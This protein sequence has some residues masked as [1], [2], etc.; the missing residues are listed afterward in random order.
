MSELLSLFGGWTWW[1]LACLLLILELMAPGVF[2]IWLGLAAAAVGIIELFID[3]SWQLEI[4][5]FGVLSLLLVLVARPWV[6]KRQNIDT[7]QPNLNRRMLDYVGRKFIL[8]RDIVNGRGAIRV[9][10]TLWD[11]L[12]PDQKAGSWIIVTGVDGLRLTVTPAPEEGA[13]I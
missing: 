10:D 7:D 6:L 3:L 9:D 4:A 1:I 5:L 13:A 11:V 8:E 2:L 12:G